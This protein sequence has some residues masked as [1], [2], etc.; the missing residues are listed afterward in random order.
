MHA[1]RILRVTVLLV[2]CASIPSGAGTSATAVPGSVETILDQALQASGVQD[3]AR[4]DAYTIRFRAMLEEIAREAG[5]GPPTYRRARR[6]HRILHDTA[7][8][9]YEEAADG[10]PSI[11]DRGTFNC[12]SATLF[13]GLVARSLGF[14]ARVVET[15][16]HLSLR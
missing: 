7:L 10:I 8:R 3:P 14:E 6:L 1:S 13:S 2:L 4:R 11:L 9:Q 12:V 5:Q 16:R 15:P